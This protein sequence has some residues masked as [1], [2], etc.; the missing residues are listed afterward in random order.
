MNKWIMLFFGWLL[1][2][3]AY[4]SIID[5]CMLFIELLAAMWV[6]IMVIVIKDKLSN[7]KRNKK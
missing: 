6:T 2:G 1:K 5:I 3:R 7:K 4:I